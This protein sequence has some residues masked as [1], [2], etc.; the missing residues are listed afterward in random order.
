MWHGWCLWFDVQSVRWGHA[1]LCNATWTFGQ[2]F[3]FRTGWKKSARMYIR[4]VITA[5]NALL[6]LRSAH[7][8]GEYN[9]LSL[10]LCVRVLCVLKCIMFYNGVDGGAL[11]AVSLYHCSGCCEHVCMSFEFSTELLCL[12]DK[13]LRVRVPL[14]ALENFSSNRWKRWCCLI[15]NAHATN[16]EHSVEK[17]NP[18]LFLCFWCVKTQCT[19]GVSSCLLCLCKKKKRRCTWLVSGFWHMLGWE[20]KVMGNWIYLPFLSRGEKQLYARGLSVII[21]LESGWRVLAGVWCK[22]FPCIVLGVI[23]GGIFFFPN[24]G[25]AQGTSSKSEIRRHEVQWS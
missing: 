21:S 13:T 25:C 24:D 22:L 19:S 7:W 23:S 1:L 12:L 2:C 3:F 10:S 18:L 16:V 20:W 15:S 4:F 14:V 5:T 17:W 11:T 8:V 9:S 6:G